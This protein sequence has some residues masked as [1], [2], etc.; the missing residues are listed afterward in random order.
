MIPVVHTVGTSLPPLNPCKL[1][2]QNVWHYFKNMFAAATRRSRL[3]LLKIH[4]GMVSEQFA[5]FGQFSVSSELS[6]LKSCSDVAVSCG[7]PRYARES[8]TASILKESHAITAERL[9]KGRLFQQTLQKFLKAF[10]RRLVTRKSKRFKTF[11]S[12]QSVLPSHSDISLWTF[13]VFISIFFAS[14]MLKHCQV[15]GENPLILTL[16]LLPWCYLS[17][18]HCFN[19]L[20]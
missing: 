10:L 14:C 19:Y 15:F 16:V 1:V 12:Y 5:L 2:P 18:G 17:R 11:P 6:T 4:C 8:S 9:V 13:S 3:R 7:F 20:K